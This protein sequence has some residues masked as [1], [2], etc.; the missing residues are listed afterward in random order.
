[1]ELHFSSSFRPSLIE[2]G[3]RPLHFVGQY[4]TYWMCIQKFGFTN[5]LRL[6]LSFSSLLL[7]FSYQLFIDKDTGSGIKLALSKDSSLSVEVGQG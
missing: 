3:L 1:M 2:T 7:S 6:S 5:H 4:P